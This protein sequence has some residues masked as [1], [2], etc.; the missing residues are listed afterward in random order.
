MN[1]KFAAQTLSSS[2]A[3]AI[4]FLMFSKHPN[5]K[6]AEGAINFI[7][8]IDELFVMLNSKNLFSKS[9]EKALFLNDYPYWNLTFDQ[10][11]NYLSKL[12]DANGT[13]L[14]KHRRKTF[15]LGLIVATKS[16]QHLAYELLTLNVHPF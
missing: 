11:I 9:Y 4:E 6:H 5:F 10:I 15:V 16:L 2:V 3:D 14:L 7:R 12:T 1:V 8:V 13:L